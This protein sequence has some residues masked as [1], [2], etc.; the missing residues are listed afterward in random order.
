MSPEQTALLQKAQ[1]SIETARL[2]ISH[3][4]YAEF[5][6][7][8]AYYAMFYA[9]EAALLGEGFSSSKHGVVIAKFGELLCKTGKLP[10]HLHRYLIDGQRDRTTGDYET[11]HTLSPQKAQEHILHAEEFLAAVGAFLNPATP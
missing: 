4:P 5:A 6:I 7:S 11:G 10:L 8:R 9:A 3:L 2:I 1:A